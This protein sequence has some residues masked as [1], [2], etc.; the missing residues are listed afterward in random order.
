MNMPHEASAAWR[1][2]T[3]LIR[4]APTQVGQSSFT[5]FGLSSRTSHNDRPMRR[6]ALRRPLQARHIL[7]ML[8]SPLGSSTARPQW[9]R[10]HRRRPRY[11]AARPPGTPSGRKP[12]T[13]M[14]PSPPTARRHRAQRPA[15][16][17]PPRDGTTSRRKSGT[18]AEA[19]GR[20]S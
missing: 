19:V 10:G 7:G 5:R 8:S 2:R 20:D 3:P 4:R 13:R 16:P 14:A 11:H 6:R 18:A 1:R 9:R 12:G 17:R 15:R